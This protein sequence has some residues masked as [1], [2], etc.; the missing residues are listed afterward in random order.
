MHS[1]STVVSNI[2]KR[3]GYAVRW[4]RPVPRHTGTAGSGRPRHGASS[5]RRADKGLTGDR[6]RDG[7]LWSWE[8]RS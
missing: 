1:I 6:D 2:A 3:E 5:F 7:G 4:I 8:V